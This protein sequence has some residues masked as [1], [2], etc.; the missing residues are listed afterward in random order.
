MLT[1]SKALKSAHGITK[2]SLEKAMLMEKEIKRK[3]GNNNHVLN[4]ETISA[5]IVKDLSIESLLPKQTWGLSR[6]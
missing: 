3:E 6:S 2:G 5:S 4:L 1:I